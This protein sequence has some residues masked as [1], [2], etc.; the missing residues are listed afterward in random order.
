[1]FFCFDLSELG[2]M[3]TLPPPVHVFVPL[4]VVMLR[5]PPTDR[6]N[7]T[8]NPPVSTCACWIAPQGSS[9][10]PSWVSA[11]VTGKPLT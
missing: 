11:L 8:P 5:T 4:L 1:M 2:S 6:P 7:S 10:E 9:I 3:E